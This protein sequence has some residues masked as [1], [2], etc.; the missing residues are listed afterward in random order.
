MAQIFREMVRP[1]PTSTPS[2]RDIYRYF[3]GHTGGVGSDQPWSHTQRQGQDGWVNPA[4]SSFDLTRTPRGGEGGGGFDEEWSIRPDS[5]LAQLNERYGEGTAQN[6]IRRSGNDQTWVEQP[7]DFSRLPRTRFGSVENTVPVGPS[8]RLLNPD[9]VYDDP[10]Y[11]RITHRGNVQ[12]RSPWLGPALMGIVGLGAGSLVGAAGGA[13]AANSFRQAMG[14]ARL[15][16]GV[17]QGGNPWAAAGSAA[18]GFTGL[19]NWVTT[20]ANMA[21]NQLTRRGRR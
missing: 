15:I 2:L 1:R 8:M 4:G 19:P 11:G 17:G 18:L 14:L 13:A 16:Q 7:I 10:V 21:I 12:S 6:P 3:G 20:P 9:L 5:F